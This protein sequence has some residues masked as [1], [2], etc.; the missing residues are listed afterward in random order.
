MDTRSDIILRAALGEDRAFED[1][2]SQKIAKRSQ[3]VRAVIVAK[4]RFVIAGL[5]FAKRVFKL[6]DRRVRVSLKVGEGDWVPKGRIVAKVFGDAISILSAE[7]TALNILQHLSGIATA[8]RNTVVKTKRY[9]VQVLDTR[10]TLPGLRKLQKYAV[11]VGGGINHRHSLSD[12]IL[13][14]N[15]HLA[16]AGGV[17]ASLRK[18]PKR[19]RG[20]VQVEVRSLRDARAAIT[21]GARKLL[22]DNQTPV[23]LKG[24]VRAIRKIRPNIWIEASGGITPQNAEAYARTGVNAISLGALTHS[25]RAVD[26]SLRVSEPSRPPKRSQRA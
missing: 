18:I 24:W 26:L 6:R 7:R 12:A 22:L 19:L 15:N 9:G 3:K 20:R 23:K 11:R 2:T 13:I 17:N 14:K 5:P 21:S 1:H 16:I 25:P 4:E 10:K 8:T